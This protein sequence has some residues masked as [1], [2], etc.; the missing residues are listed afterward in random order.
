M[1]EPM[2]VELHNALVFSGI[3]PDSISEWHKKGE[4]SYYIR[5]KPDIQVVNIKINSVKLP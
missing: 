4:A 2:P 5:Q 3:D 1:K